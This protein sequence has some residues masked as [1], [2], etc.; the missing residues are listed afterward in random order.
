MT[1]IWYFAATF[2]DNLYETWVGAKGIVDSSVSYKYII[3]FFWTFQTVTTV[4]YGDF[5]ISTTFEYL[6]CLFWMA[7]GVNVYSMAIGIISQI[8]SD[9]D[10]EAAVLNA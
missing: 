6:I 8:I 2:E 9:S 10:A 4:G 3:S 7:V 5:S 1:C